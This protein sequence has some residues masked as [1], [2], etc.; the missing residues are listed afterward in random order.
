LLSAR[1]WTVSI[2]KWPKY[3]LHLSKEGKNHPALVGWL[4]LF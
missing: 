4:I 1:I 2:L 3:P